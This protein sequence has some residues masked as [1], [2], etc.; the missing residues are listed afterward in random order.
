MR[1][2]PL[3]CTDTLTMSYLD[4]ITALNQCGSKHYL[5]LIVDDSTVGRLDPAFAAH[6]A[7]WPAVFV[8]SDDAVRL[9]DGI[10]GFDARSQAVAEV[11]GALRAKGVI[12][13]HHG[14]PY[15]VAADFSS[16]ALLTIDRASVAYFGV[17]AY[18]QHLNGFVRDGDELLMWLGRRSC[19]KPSYPGM[20][21]QLVAGGLPHGISLQ[22]NLAKECWEEAAIP[23][24]LARQAVP[25][26]TVSYCRETDAG[27][28]ADLLFNYDLELP[29]DFVP[30]AND[31]EMEDFLLLP[32]AE[33]AQL[34]EQ[35]D[36]FKD[37]C[38]LVAIDFLI[39]HGFLGPE[40]PEYTALCEGL[41]QSGRW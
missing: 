10:Q 18:G 36:E 23:A 6:L 28:K 33:V 16:P 7:R 25:V 12:A 27:I 11:V 15:R 24:E 9:A 31:G 5:P 32:L 38:I 20:L 13:R 37:N 3:F 4:P 2:P 19:S 34:V 26:G 29:A 40:H 30:R 1:T 41:H 14:E 21:D 17:R 22:D 8:V 39:R 35:G